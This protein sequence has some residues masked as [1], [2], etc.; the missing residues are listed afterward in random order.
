MP[1]ATIV[2][3]DLFVGIGAC[4]RKPLQWP[5]ELWRNGEPERNIMGTIPS[6]AA[7]SWRRPQSVHP[8]T[9]RGTSKWP[10]WPHDVGDGKSSNAN[11]VGEYLE[12]LYRNSRRLEIVHESRHLKLKQQES[13]LSAEESVTGTALVRRKLLFLRCAATCEILLQRRGCQKAVP[14][15][16]LPPVI[17]LRCDGT[18]SVSSDNRQTDPRDRSTMENTPLTRKRRDYL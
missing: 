15:A 3:S 13:S 11:G 12:H 10:Q 5:S 6:S 8:N 18:R 9:R 17:G 2:A 14:C 4:G 1:W 7:A 16:G